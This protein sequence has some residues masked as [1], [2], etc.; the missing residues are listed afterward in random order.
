MHTDIA[1]RT[2]SVALSDVETHS[3]GGQLLGVC[4]GDFCGTESLFVPAQ[5]KFIVFLIFV[6]DPFVIVDTQYMQILKLLAAESISTVD[7]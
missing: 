5:R 6:W 3:G 1:R 4:A 7:I 2:V